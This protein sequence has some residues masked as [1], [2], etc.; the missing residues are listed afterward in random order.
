MKTLTGNRQTVL[1]TLH[2]KMMP[3]HVSYYSIY[4]I[5]FTVMFETYTTVIIYY[6]CK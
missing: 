6:I 5:H 4:K 2:V 3:T 1:F